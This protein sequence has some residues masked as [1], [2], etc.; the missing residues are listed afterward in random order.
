MSAMIADARALP[1][2]LLEMPCLRQVALNP[3]ALQVIAA[4][5]GPPLAL[6]LTVTP[7]LYK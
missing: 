6:S 4:V 3:A 7:S 1:L 5:P 2:H